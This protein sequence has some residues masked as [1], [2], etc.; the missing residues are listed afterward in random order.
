MSI[1]GANFSNIGIKDPN[2][3]LESSASLAV[4]QRSFHSAAVRQ[5][6][7]L[8]TMSNQVQDLTDE[9][10]AFEKIARTSRLVRSG[11]GSVAASASGAAL[12]LSTTGSASTLQ[13]SEVINTQTAGYSTT[14]PAWT[15]TMRTGSAVNGTSTAQVT[16]S[17]NY[18][19]DSSTTLTFESLRVATVGGGSQNIGIRIYDGN[20]V[21]DTLTWT[22]SDPAGTEMTSAATGLTLSFDSGGVRR[23]D[24]FTVDVEVGV[25]QDVDPDA[26]LDAAGF[27]PGTTLA[28][29]SFEINGETITVDPVT[30]TLNDVLDE[31]NA[32]GAGVTATFADDM[33]SIVSNTDGEDPISISGDTTGLIA[34][35]KLDPGAATAGTQDDRVAAMDSVDAFSGVS[36]GSFT[37]NGQSIS[38]DPSSDSLTDIL[39]AIN[40]ADAGALASLSNGVIKIRGVDGASVTLGGDT[41]GF[42]AAAGLDEGTYEP[43]E[44]SGSRRGSRQAARRIASAFVDLADKINAIFAPNEELDAAARVNRISMQSKIRASIT[45]TLADRDMSATDNILDVTFNTED[46]GEAMLTLRRADVKKLE[47]ALI[48]NPRDASRLLFGSHQK[49]GLLSALAEGAEAAQDELREA[50]DGLGSVLHTYA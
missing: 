15:D 46:D 39:D 5:S 9:L 8:R 28:A 24:T 18:T 49:N 33:V 21:L 37:V 48:D 20:T 2:A 26:V 35:L 11:G 1:A 29:G 7:A 16:I 30:D 45:S 12:S 14:T 44:G 13:S 27:E 25:E 50:M 41:S 34:A 31:I 3:L 38:V 17:G 43:T 6:G 10:R 47:K 19:G 42:L 36:S 4:L 23:R 22:P 32:S 40:D